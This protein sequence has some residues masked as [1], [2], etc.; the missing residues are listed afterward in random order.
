MSSVFPVLKNSAPLLVMTGLSSM[1]S[2]QAAVLTDPTLYDDIDPAGDAAIA[3]SAPG[4][5]SQSTLEGMDNFYV[6]QDF[7]GFANG[8]SANYI[9]FTDVTLPDLQF[10]AQGGASDGNSGGAIASSSLNT[11]PGTAI[12]I[13]NNSGGTRTV[14]LTV[15]FGSYADSAFDADVNPVKAAGFALTN[16]DDIDGVTVRFYDASDNIVSTQ[17]VTNTVDNVF[18]G[19]DNSIGSG[20]SR[21]RVS[22]SFDSGQSSIGFD[23]LGFVIVPEPGTYA[24]CFGLLSGG[25]VLSRRARGVRKA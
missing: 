25:L 22:G 8:T 10:I 24:L 16:L 13:Y 2:L 5:M 14:N 23:D 6:V 17:T 20:I 12:R 1:I 19:Y 11:S 7:T 9:S 4:A 15:D 21:I 18:F 3:G